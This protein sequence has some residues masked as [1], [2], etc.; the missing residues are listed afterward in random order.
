MLCTDA[1][2]HIAAL[3]A[4]GCAS[5]IPCMTCCAIILLDIL[6]LLASAHR[7]GK[8]CRLHHLILGNM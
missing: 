7:F 3:M 1:P 5:D 2:C 4:I 8:L 6:N